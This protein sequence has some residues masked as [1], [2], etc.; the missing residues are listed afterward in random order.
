MASVYE[1]NAIRVL[2]I[3]CITRKLL[4]RVLS[5]PRKLLFLPYNV[6]A[7]RLYVMDHMMD[8]LNVLCME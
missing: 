7:C 4:F 6:K 5:V 3:E 1:V 2:K 8:T